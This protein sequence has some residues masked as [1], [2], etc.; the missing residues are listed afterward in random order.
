MR[1]RLFVAAAA[2]CLASAGPARAAAP[3]L[4]VKFEHPKAAAAAVTSLGDSPVA[5]AAGGV[6]VVRIGGGESIAHALS[7]YRSR[8]DVV[9]AEPNRAV[10]ALGL[11]DPDDP[12]F[13][14]QWSLAKTNAVA[15]WALFPGAYGAGG[16]ATIAVVDTGVDAA[17]ED[18]GGRVRTDL[19]ASCLGLLPCAAG[20]ADDDNDHGTHVAGIAA[21]TTNNGLGVAGVSFSSQIIPVKVLDSAGDGTD[22][23]VANGIVWAAQNGARVINLSLGGDYSQTV[24]DA[25]GIAETAYGALVVAAAGNGSSSTP[26]VP[27]GC[28]GAVGVAATDSSDAPA[29]FSNFGAPDVFVSAPGTNILSTWSPDAYAY[30]DGTSMAAP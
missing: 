19:G 26:V 3:A 13:G 7:D 27:G 12:A 1:S 28:P 29:S 2:A 20:P 15:G 4:L 25:V 23:D 17:H 14:L 16:G 30:A 5:Q 8:D 10:H 6:N 21:A 11:A 24:C 22:V 18:L 9:Y